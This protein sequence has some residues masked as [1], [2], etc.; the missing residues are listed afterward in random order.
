MSTW[1]IYVIILHCNDTS[2]SLQKAEDTLTTVFND[3]IRVF[4]NASLAEKQRYV[5]AF[6][7]VVEK[8]GLAVTHSPSTYRL[9]GSQD[10]SLCA[11]IFPLLSIF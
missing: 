6:S 9:W 4:S 7:R 5:E 2:Q 8:Q 1:S 11:Q 3:F 10:V